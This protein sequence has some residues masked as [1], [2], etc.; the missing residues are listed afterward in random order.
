MDGEEE[1]DPDALSVSRLCS[2]LTEEVMDDNSVNL[3]GI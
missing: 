2:D 1:V 3:N